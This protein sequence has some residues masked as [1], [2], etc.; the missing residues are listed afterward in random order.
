R[1]WSR[2]MMIWKSADRIARLMARVA[3]AVHHAHQHNLLHRDLKPGNIL[4]H[5]RDHPYVADFGLVMRIEDTGGTCPVEGTPPYMA[6][7]QAAGTAPLSTAVDVYGLGAVLYELLTG[8]PPFTGDSTTEILEKVRA[9]KPV[10]PS[11]L[12]PAI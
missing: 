5:G 9:G 1:S 3:E 6:P 11:Q 8:R 4:L 10:Q 2:G 7:E 12:E